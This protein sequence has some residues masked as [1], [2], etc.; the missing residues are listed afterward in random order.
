MSATKALLLV[1]ILSSISLVQGFSARHGRQWDLSCDLALTTATRR[2]YNNKDF[3]ST[4]ERLRASA[5]TTHLA[6]S[7]NPSNEN[8]D[9]EPIPPETALSPSSLF[10]ESSAKGSAPPVDPDEKY[11][12][13][14]SIR[15]KAP[16]VLDCL[17]PLF[18]LTRPI[19]F[20][21]VIL[22]H[23][24]GG[25]LSLAHTGQGHLFKKIMLQTPSMYS[26]LAALLLT[27]S[28]SM[29]VN[30]Y[31]DKKLGRDTDKKS[32]PLVNGQVTLAIVRQYLNYLYA[33][34]LICLA[35]VPG[36][37][38]RMS[39]VFGL[40]LTFWYTKHL[41]PLTWIKNVMC[42]SLIALS[43]FT[44]GSAAL[45]VA[46]EIA[47]GPFSPSALAIP[48]LF[49]LVGMLFFGVCG[50]EIM[51]DITD[52][53]DDQLNSVRT[54]P[55]KYGRKFASAVAMVCYAL[56]GVGVL[57]GPL[58]KLVSQ[59]GGSISLPFVKSVLGADLGGLTRRLAFACIGSFMLARRGIQ[60]FRANGE[61]NTLISRAVEEAQLALVICLFSFI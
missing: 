53:E 59:L 39:V 18:Q 29:V 4:R 38:A 42:A 22:F 21:G 37:P 47:G 41:K 11:Y 20:P 43:P 9:A 13:N 12:V 16:S 2:Y 33:I 61:N 52:I 36:V 17:G 27:S 8:G 57:A 31:Y 15:E 24:L 26:V 54:I 48:S 45:K 40:M 3:T 46:N 23:L 34:A 50:R 35:M 28:T 44:S 55:V 49:R 25:Y 19:N 30:D 58:A 7:S 1:S 56:A 60:V 10:L 32:S 14:G 51:M 5:S 6:S